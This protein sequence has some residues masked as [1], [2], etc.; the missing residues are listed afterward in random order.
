MCNKLRRNRER[1]WIWDGFLASNTRLGGI[2]EGFGGQQQGRP[3]PKEKWVRHALVGD[4]AALN[5]SARR[6]KSSCGAGNCARREGTRR[7]ARERST[8]EE[9]SSGSARLY[10]GLPNS[11]FARSS[12]LDRSKD[13]E[14]G[15][16]NR[17]FFF[18]PSLFNN[19]S[20]TSNF[21]LA[22]QVIN[23]YGNHI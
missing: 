21:C 8:R 7:R 13:V 3:S 11:D 12:R 15:G 19:F 22:V 23:A 9:G 4:D 10:R 16:G 17:F 18:L 6:K 14:S 1:G 20:A 2:W 5:K